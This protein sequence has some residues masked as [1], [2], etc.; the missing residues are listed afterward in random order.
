[1]SSCRGICVRLWGG[2]G[3]RLRFGRLRFGRLRF[4]RLR[5]GHASRCG[6]HN[7]GSRRLAKCSRNTIFCVTHPH[8]DRFVD[9]LIQ[10]SPTGFPFVTQR[11]F[12]DHRVESPPC[13]SRTFVVSTL[14]TAPICRGPLVKK[15]SRTRS[16]ETES[17]VGRRSRR[18][19]GVMRLYLLFCV[20]LFFTPLSSLA[21][22]AYCYSS[23]HKHETNRF[24][25]QM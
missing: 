4:G 24:E 2:I 25:A 1:L 11:P 5:F 19:G 18:L 7:N 22:Y 16:H 23:K 14:A 20:R 9:C 13:L 15:C 12:D 3:G 6:R 10:F 21:S 17:S 8:D